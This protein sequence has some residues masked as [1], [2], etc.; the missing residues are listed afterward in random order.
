MSEDETVTDRAW[1][2]GDLARWTGASGEFFRQEIEA[3]RLKGSRFG[4][5]YYVHVT[6][7]CRY[8]TAK[9]WPVPSSLGT[10]L[11]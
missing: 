2:T 7:V 3:G 4:R 5:V 9:G 8:L 11:L 6:E 1:S 10:S